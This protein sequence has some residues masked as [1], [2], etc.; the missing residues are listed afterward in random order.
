[1]DRNWKYKRVIVRNGATI[2]DDTI[3]YIHDSAE[4]IIAIVPDQKNGELMA[5][6]PRM[7]DM[8]ESV[9]L[10][11]DHMAPDKDYN[12]KQSQTYYLLKKLIKEIKGY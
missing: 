8:L 9:K 7:A 2:V 6:A 11:L 10:L 5:L 12:L 4:N 1:M 3:S